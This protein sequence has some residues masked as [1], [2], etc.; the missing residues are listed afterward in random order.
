[1]LAEMTE[2]TYQRWRLF[3]SEEP[4]GWQVQNMMMAS[5]AAAAAHS[6]DVDSFLPMTSG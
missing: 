5:V 2:D 6:G 3:W 1:M 4:F